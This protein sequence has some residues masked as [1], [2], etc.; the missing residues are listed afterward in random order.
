MKPAL[1]VGISSK[2]D[3]VEIAALE[4]GRVAVSIKFPATAMGVEAIKL[5]LAD[6]AVPVR[7]AVGGVAALSLALTL[8]NA[9]RREVFIVASGLMGPS[10]ALAHYAKHSI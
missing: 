8:G 3:N 7:L 4:P 5:F 6:Y 1:Y 2:N 10:V 9:P